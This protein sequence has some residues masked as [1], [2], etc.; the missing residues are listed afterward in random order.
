MKI[1]G[2]EFF[3]TLAE[4]LNYSDAADRLFITQS[5]L[6]RTI[7][8][9]EREMGVKLFLRTHRS[10]RLTPAGQSFIDDARDL[11]SR[12]RASVEHA[13][14]AYRGE[15]G[16]LTFGIH[17]ASVSPVLFDILN[18]CSKTFPKIAI[19]LDSSSTS[20][21]LSALA[22][23][24]VDIILSSSTLQT[25]GI[26]E[27]PVAGYEDC[28]VVAR[29][30]P[31]S[32]E[33][34]VSVKKLR[35]EPFAVMNRKSSGRGY[36]MVYGIARTGGFSPRVEITAN[37]VPH[38]MALVATGNYVTFLSNNYQYMA[39]D[40]LAFVPLKEQSLSDLY[41]EWRT[42]NL[43]P[44]IKIITDFIRTHFKIK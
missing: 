10:V 20:D 21:M 16:R 28:L 1:E 41:L 4:T 13:H 9:M 19:D 44:C 22:E 29:N 31:L 23:N 42:D 40:R 38:L 30:H 17:N 34:I 36:D 18:A 8:Q 14:N 27:I 11:V 35:N 37:N 7:Q 15:E 3:L 32:T 5:A 26:E 43:N 25:S 24:T 2:I 33:S 39:F 6:S 12:Y